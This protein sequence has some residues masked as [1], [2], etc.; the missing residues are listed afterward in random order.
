[1]LF[2]GVVGAVEALS[3]EQLAPD[4]DVCGMLPGTGKALL[5]SKLI[6]E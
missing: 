6:K 2:G 1:M 5:V 3:G 4:G